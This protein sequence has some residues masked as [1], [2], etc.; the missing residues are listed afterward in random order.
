MGT[1]LET[2]GKYGKLPASG[3]CPIEIEKIV[4][5]STDPFTVIEISGELAGKGRV[6]GLQMAVVK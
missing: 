2:V 6:D 3:R 1:A 4:V 5:R